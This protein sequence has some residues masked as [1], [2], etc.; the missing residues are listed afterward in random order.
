MKASIWKWLV[1]IV[2]VAWSIALV[3]PPKDKVKLGLDLQGGTSY[4]LEIDESQLP[5]G[6]EITTS[7]TLSAAN[8]KKPDTQLYFNCVSF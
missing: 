1:L 7:S 6:S 5:E 4:T 2:L 3:Y 8:R